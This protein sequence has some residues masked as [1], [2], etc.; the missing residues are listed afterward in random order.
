MKKVLALILVLTLVLAFAG[1]SKEVTNT[2]DD[3]EEKETITSNEVYIKPDVNIKGAWIV[4]ATPDPLQINS[5]AD[6]QDSAKLTD[7]TIRASI[8]SIFPVG[9]II[10][11]YENGVAS[12]NLP[13]G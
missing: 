9:G 11:V 3:E 5:Y 10:D 4:T 8:N 12:C 1:C 6:Y 13:L 2:K 7:S